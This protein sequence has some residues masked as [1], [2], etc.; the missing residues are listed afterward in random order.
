MSPV[1]RVVLVNKPVKSSSA[2][3]SQRH[4]QCGFYRASLWQRQQTGLKLA[5][6][7]GKQRG[8][9]HYST[10][11]AVSEHQEYQYSSC[12]SSDA[13][14]RARSRQLAPQSALS[15]TF[16]GVRYVQA[17]ALLIIRTV[18]F[19]IRKEE[20]SCCSHSNLQVCQ[21][22]KGQPEERIQKHLGL[23]DGLQMERIGPWFV[24]MLAFFIMVSRIC[25]IMQHLEAKPRIWSCLFERKCAYLS[26]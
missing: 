1:N 23:L 7:R 14:I 6:L 4:T 13:H 16:W 5:A 26:F 11:P 12:C 2:A 8:T 19:G 17:T 3:L 25:F 9:R 21:K 10:F 24:F 15:Q 20:H 18:G 22:E